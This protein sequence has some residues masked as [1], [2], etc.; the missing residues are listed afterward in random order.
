MQIIAKALLILAV[1]SQVATA[2]NQA[3]AD[4]LKLLLKNNQTLSALNKM[5][6][7]TS[8]LE[9]S[10]SPEEVLLYANKLLDLATKNNQPSH[11]ITAYHFKGVSYRLT[12]NLKLSLENL[13]KSA[14]LAIDVKNNDLLIDA[15]QEIANTYTG[16]KDYKNALV[17]NTKSLELI[18]QHGNKEQLAIGLLNTGYN[19][20]TLKE[21]DPALK[22]YNEAEP[23]F[24]SIEM[25][26]GKAYVTGNRALVYWKQGNYK[27]AE[28]DL[29]RAMQMLEVLGDEF[30]IADYQNQLGRIYAEQGK[31]ENAINYT[32]K[33]L[34]TSKSQNLKEQIRDALKLLSELYEKKSD[35]NQAFRFQSQYIVYKD[36]IENSENTKRIAN[37]RTEFEVSQREK[38]ITELKKNQLLNRIYIIVAV[39]LLLITLLLLLYFRQRLLNTRL[40]AATERKE[41]DEKIKGLLNAQ[42]TRALQ[43]MVK[44]REEERKRIAHELHNHFGSLMATIKINFNAIDE[45]AISNYNTLI[46]LIDQACGDIRDLSHSLNMGISKDF[47][48][49]PALKELTTHLQHAD[50]I[51]VEFVASMGSQQIDFETEIVI[52]R[53]IQELI[54]NVLKHAKATRLSIL[55]TF[56]ED[57]N[58]MNILVQDNGKGFDV[59]KAKKI[60]RGMGLKSL[61]DMIANLKGDIIFDSNPSGGTTVNIDLPITPITLI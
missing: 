39:S 37:L 19:Y 1:F 45:H 21:F 33:A 2:Q 10:S 26:I 46:T 11:L 43:S 25:K 57:E 20:Y 3:K 28:R 5:V 44:G 14:K 13:F 6:V 36:S 50:G 61:K 34:N 12:G 47:G 18:R 49:L 29:L 15:Y 51:D 17:Y 40:M 60:N 31:L 52:Y 58:L 16:N 4:S 8:I 7:Y 48:L 27:I 55:L 32:Q 41:H 22:L 30:A 56:F 53:I 23:I 9:Y 38:K 42:E 24:E 59:K 54:S 35:Y